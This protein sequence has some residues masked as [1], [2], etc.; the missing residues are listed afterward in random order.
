MMP[1]RYIQR[2]DR[3]FELPSAGTNRPKE[4]DRPTLAPLTPAPRQA[5]L[6]F[7]ARRQLLANAAI[8][9][10]RVW[11]DSS[12]TTSTRVEPVA[13]LAHDRKSMLRARVVRACRRESA[14]PN[15]YRA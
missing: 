6:F 7:Q 2:R 12:G 4:R 10:S 13:L 14:D 1:K 11:R 9:S 3:R 8:A 5:G 15:R